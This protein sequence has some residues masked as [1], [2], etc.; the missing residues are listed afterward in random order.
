MKLVKSALNRLPLTSLRE[1]AREAVLP[2]ILFNT[3]PKSGSVF[4]TKTLTQGL[5]FQHLAV[6][7]GYF[8]VDLIDWT[9]L[10][11][12]A[13]GNHVSQEHF[14]A[15]EMNLQILRHFKP[16]MVLHLRDPRQATLSFLHHTVR[17]FNEGH[18]DMA[19]QICPTPGKD[20]YFESLSG[21]IDWMIENYLTGAV[22]WICD[23][24]A[25]ADAKGLDILITTYED[26]VSD[27]QAL[28]HR[29]LDFY[30]IPR[31]RFHAVALA[32]TMENHY[33]KGKVAEWK[34][35]FSPRQRERATAV[36]TQKLIDRF[37]WR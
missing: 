4:I 27:N 16:R 25:V 30:G 37:N 6:S 22:K 15:S 34:E 35:V 1:G 23:W 9:K 32:K 17:L 36:V 19:F 12:A 18:G 7:L 14:D 28:Y 13:Q 33:R 29:I 24:L 11:R 8:P 10:K 21:Q 20:F 26:F 31:E 3:L 5:G 2:S